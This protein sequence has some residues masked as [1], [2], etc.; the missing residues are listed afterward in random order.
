M[1]N[2]IQSLY[3]SNLKYMDYIHIFN[4]IQIE[5]NKNNEFKNINIAILKSFTFDYI[6]EPLTVEAFREKYNSKIY[7]SGY[8]QYAQEILNENSELYKI[9]ADLVILALR[10]EEV[11]PNI[12]ISYEELKPQIESLSDSIISDYE[13]L[14]HT[15]QENTKASILVNNFIVPINNYSGLL[16]CMDESSQK[17]FIRNLNL[18]LT[19]MVANLIGVYV[20]DT[21]QLAANMGKK[22]IFDKKMWYISK[23]PYKLNFYVELSKEYVK[24]IKAINGD[25]KKCIVLDL[26]NTLWGGIIGEDGFNNIRL[27]NNYPGICYKEF[28]LELRKL[29]KRG[30]LLAINSKNNYEDAMEIIN[31]HPDMILKENDFSSIKINWLDKATNLKAISEELNIDISSIIFIDDNPAE[32]ELINQI[33]DGRVGTIT[34]PPNLLEYSEILN[35]VNYF[36]ALHIT[37]EDINR[38]DIYRAQSKRNIFKGTNIDLET[39]YRS[40]EMIADIKCVDDFS[41][42]RIAQLTQKS[43]QFNMTTRRYTEEDIINMA[44]SEDYKIYYMKVIDKFGDNG[45]VGVC[46]I[47]LKLLYTWHID[48]FLLSCRV[49]ERNLE[50][51]FMAFINNKAKENNMH[52]LEGEYIPTPKN[53]SVKDF[54]MRIGFSHEEDGIFRLNINK[55]EIECPNYIEI[56]E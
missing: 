53:M 6:M 25:S 31:K 52:F 45:I 23:N 38:T 22:N 44:K 47:K 13:K 26:D 40:L 35:N 50:K 15:I 7:I 51:A 10:L 46:I 24:Y 9:K 41:I 55:I 2:D 48:T 17:N 30:I 29:K 32:C 42:P 20:V 19:K 3:K 4:K 18:K 27:D 36:Q 21:D 16:D 33:F 43:N 8:N 39:Y 56:R 49:I 14:I 28:Q 1:A 5:E 37:Q 54:Y 34:M 12:F 11:Y